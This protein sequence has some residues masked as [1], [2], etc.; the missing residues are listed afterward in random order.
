LTYA[1]LA[2]RRHCFN[3]ACRV[4]PAARTCTWRDRLPLLLLP[5]VLLPLRGQC[6]DWIFMWAFAFAIFAACKWM[7]WSRARKAAPT[8]LRRS[9]A[10]LF[11]WVG[12][13]AERFLCRTC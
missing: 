11:A 13:D 8:S 1:G 6:A 3:G 4:A 2:K 7:T 10:Y 9:L 5:L 12:M